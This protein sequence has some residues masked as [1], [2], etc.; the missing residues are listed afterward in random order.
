M[1]PNMKKNMRQYTGGK[2][3][4]AEIEKRINLT[5]KL[6]LQGYNRHQIIEYFDEELQ[7]CSS[8]A[9]KYYALGL[10]RIREINKEEI[11]KEV[12]FELQRLENLYLECLKNNDRRTAAGVAKQI[13]DLKG[14]QQAT[15]LEIQAENNNNKVTINIVNPKNK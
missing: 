2:P 13:A 12:H 3:S 6:I 1:N 11:R 8:T 7:L 15:M 5:T 10:E 4:E 9:N 14:F